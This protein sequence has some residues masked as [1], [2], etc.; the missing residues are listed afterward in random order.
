MRKTILT[1][2]EL[3]WD[4]LPDQTIL[5]G[6]VFNFLPLRKRYTIALAGKQ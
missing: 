2:G 5:G 1:F 4:I 6:A 3:L